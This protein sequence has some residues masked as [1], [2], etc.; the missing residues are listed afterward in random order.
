M[1]FYVDPDISLASTIDTRFY[2]DDAVFEA[3]KELIFARS[4]QFIGIAGAD[5]DTV[6]AFPVTLLEDF[7]DEPLLVVSDELG[8][9][10]CISNVCTHR[11]AVLVKETC[12]LK[13]IRCPYHG[14]MFALDGRIQS[15]P[16]FRE[17]QNFPSEGDNLK[18]LPLEQWGKLLFTS[19]SAGNSF[20]EVFGEMMERI[21]WFPVDKLVYRADLSKDYQVKAHWAL[22]CE[23]YLEGF[24]IP[25]VHE[26]L[27]KELD[28]GSYTTEIFKYSNLQLGI[29]KVGDTCFELPP[30]SPDYGKNVA[31]YYFWVFPN[32][33]FN[34]YP[35][36][37]SLNLVLPKGKELTKVSFLTFVSDE[38]K[39]EQGAGSG[40]DSVELEDEAIVEQ[41]QRGIKSQIYRK[42]RFSATREQGPHHF[43]RLISRCFEK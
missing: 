43:H 26:A 8:N 12:K 40:L 19:L 21:S 11:G 24:H 39:L 35:W 6:N 22:Y 17:V 20:A 31:A 41:V 38:S 14:R 5:S 4:W 27:N 28:F 30:T 29:G 9:T 15:M 2:T 25:F 3:S 34:F 13:H 16:E 23:N 18:Q 10:R 1:D 7:L 37:L 32:M 42:G 33:M 36:G